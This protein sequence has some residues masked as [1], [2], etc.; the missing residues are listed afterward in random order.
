M[1]LAH[2]FFR[3]HYKAYLDIDHAVKFHGDRPTQLGA[4]M[5]KSIKNKHHL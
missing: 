4:P 2:Q 5:M 3:G 1:V